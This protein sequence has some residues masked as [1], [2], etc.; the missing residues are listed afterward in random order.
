[1]GS[2]LAKSPEPILVSSTSRYF[3]LAFAE[4]FDWALD[5][6]K[7]NGEKYMRSQ[8]GAKL[9][10]PTLLISKN[11]QYSFKNFILQCN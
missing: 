1:M 4:N 7:G 6:V 9:L 3:G 2:Y 8:K 11:L 5:C 10:L